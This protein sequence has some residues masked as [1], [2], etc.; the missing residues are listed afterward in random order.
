MDVDNDILKMV[1]LSRYDQSEP[2]IAFTKGFGLHK[3]AIASSVAHDSHNII[4]VGTNDKDLC[5][6][7]NLVIKNKGGI[8]LADGNDEDCI[9]LEVAGLMS[10]KN[11]ISLAEDY[12]KLFLKSKKLGAKLYDPFMMLSFCALLVIPELKLSDKGLF[13]GN[14]F[15]FVANKK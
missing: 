4:A 12:E 15:N 1:V 9:P 14:T 5:N 2:A 3:G 11:G 10:K 13:N 6:A 7:M 8:A